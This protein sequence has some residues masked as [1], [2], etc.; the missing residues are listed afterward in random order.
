MKNLLVVAALC[1]LVGCTSYDHFY[2]LDSEYMSRRQLETRILDS[3]DT[4]KVMSASAQVLQDLGFSLVESD[5]KLGLLT[6]AKDKEADNYNWGFSMGVLATLIGQRCK[7]DSSQKIYVM[8]VVSKNVSGKNC[9]VR[10]GFARIIY[11]NQGGSRAEQIKDTSTYK[12]FFD[13]L[14]KSLFLETNKI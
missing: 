11:D 12:V 3:Q 10:V 7:Y 5:M 4:E 6:A 14:E 9:K 1:G 13:K 2:Q 8:Q